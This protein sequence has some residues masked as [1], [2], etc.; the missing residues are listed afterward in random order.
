LQTN[1]RFEGI[2]ATFGETS[3]IRKIQKGMR[4]Q[5]TAK[6]GSTGSASVI[7][8]VEENDRFDR[9]FDV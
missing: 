7:E 2:P 6:L 1:N 3:A 4:R 8:R 9:R 5:R